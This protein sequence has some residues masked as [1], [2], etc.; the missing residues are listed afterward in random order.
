MS[1]KKSFEQAFQD[2]VYIAAPLR[3]DGYKM[4]AFMDYPHGIAAPEGIEPH[5]REEVVSLRFG[6]NPMKLARFYLRLRA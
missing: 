5:A 3:W 2:A 6:Q 1:M 4:N